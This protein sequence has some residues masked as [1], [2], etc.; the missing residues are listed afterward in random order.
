MT[1]RALR[2]RLARLESRRT[3]DAELGHELR[4]APLR[5][6]LAGQR[7]EEAARYP[8]EREAEIVEAVIQAALAGD[9]AAAKLVLDRVCPPLRPESA[10]VRLTLPEGD[11]AGQGRAVLRA[12]AAGRIGIHEGS[13]LLATVGALARVVE[14]G[15]LAARIE[16][17][18]R[19]AGDAP[20]A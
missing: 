5:H 18:G 12:V 3:G 7:L 8:A 15:E 13:A 9:T 17:L 1:E 11:L 16:A 10:P 20:G 4:E 2:A 19:R 14:T 6:W